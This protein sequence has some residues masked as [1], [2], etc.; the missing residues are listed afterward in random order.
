M[1]C[2]LD[3]LVKPTRFALRSAMLRMVDWAG[4]RMP[5]PFVIGCPRVNNRAPADC[6]KIGG[7]SPTAP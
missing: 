7:E 3:P 2:A 6:A 4:T 5:C 1:L